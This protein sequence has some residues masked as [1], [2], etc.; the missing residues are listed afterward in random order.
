MQIRGLHRAI[1]RGARLS[2]RIEAKERSDAAKRSE[3]RR[4]LVDRWL[5]ARRDGLTAEAAAEAVGKSRATL[6]RWRKELT[7]KSTRP[8][9]VR[10]PSADPR[11]AIA[12][13]RLRKKHPMWGKDTLAPLLWREGFDCSIS[14][15]GRILKKLVERGVFASVPSLRTGT[16]HAPRKHKRTY[17]KRLPKG[18]KPALPGEIVQLDTVHI[19]LAPGKSI[20]QF[21]AYCPVARWTV[22]QARNRATAAA[23]ALF[24]DKLVS[25]MPFKVKA[26]QVDG[27]SEFM[28]GFE[29]ECEKRKIDL[30]VLP[31]RSPK[32]NG[33]VER[34]NGAW[35]Y[36]FYACTDLPGSV[37]ELN[38]LID[39]WQDTYNHVRPHR[40]LSGLTPAEYLLR[41]PAP[42]RPVPSHM[43]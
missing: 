14:R 35:R 38:P 43:S 2:S 21:T 16:R 8:H 10:K 18:K 33:G 12:V 41:R 15:V 19:N 36:E 27:G 13:E 7:P 11:L 23:A 1:Y 20:R 29:A 24:L 5:Q 40:A 22:A 32:L 34:C 31:P 25:D 42:K 28:A 30:Y 26:I 3:E 37:Q 4:R 6:S 17:A 39:H 9:K